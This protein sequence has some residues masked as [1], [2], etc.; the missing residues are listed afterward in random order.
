[1][2][3]QTILK[4]FVD[5]AIISAEQASLIADYEEKKPFSIHWEL[6]SILYLGIVLFGSG[7]GVI[8]YENIDTIGHQVI[9]ALIA[10]LTAWCFFYTYKHALPYS[11]LEVKN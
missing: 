7:I 1:M 4:S 9:M 2:N 11:N 8:I 10:T 3:I 5:K 6:R